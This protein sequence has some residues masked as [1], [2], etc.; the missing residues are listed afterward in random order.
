M[1]S[2]GFQP[3]PP[4]PADLGEEKPKKETETCGQYSVG[5]GDPHRS[6]EIG[7]GISKKGNE[8]C[9]YRSVGSGDPHRSRPSPIK[10]IPK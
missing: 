7:G 3:P 1:T 10:N 2:S 9:G 5:S 4:N 8:T 6:G